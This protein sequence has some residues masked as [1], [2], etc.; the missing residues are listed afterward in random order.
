V[1]RPDA[2]VDA[3]AAALRAIVG[4]GVRVEAPG[5]FAAE[6]AVATRSVTAVFWLLSALVV[7]VAMFL[8]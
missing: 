8:L 1:A 2:D 6:T 4:A 3:L 5:A 7:I